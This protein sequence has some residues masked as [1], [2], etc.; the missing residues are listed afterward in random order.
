MPLRQRAGRAL[1]RVQIAEAALPEG[2]D[3]VERTVDSHVSRIRKKLG[4]TAGARIKTV[5]G[6]G[7]RCEEGDGP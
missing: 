4:P 3:R 1:T 6:I 5:W 2:G 7:Y